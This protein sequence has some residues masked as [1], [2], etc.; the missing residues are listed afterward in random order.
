MSLRLSRVRTLILLFFR[1]FLGRGRSLIQLPYSLVTR[2]SDNGDTDELTVNDSVPEINEDEAPVQ[3]DIS[4]FIKRKFP[5]FNLETTT[6]W[7]NL[8]YY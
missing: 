6:R 5:A 1:E 4:N 2:T 8:R 3:L 7:F